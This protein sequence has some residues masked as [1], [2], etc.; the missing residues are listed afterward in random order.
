MEVV[1]DD[2]LPQLRS[3]GGRNRRAKTGWQGPQGDSEAW[4]IQGL[5]VAVFESVAMAGLR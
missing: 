2:G 5:F 3:S 1:K 4:P